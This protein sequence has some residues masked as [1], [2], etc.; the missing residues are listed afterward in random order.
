MTEPLQ[1]DGAIVAGDTLVAA[2]GKARRRFEAAGLEQPVLDARLLLEEAAGVARLDIVTDPHRPLTAAQ[3]Q[4]YERVAA[5]RAAR[6]PVSHILGRKGF[7]TL[8]LTVTP[9]VLSPRPETELLVEAVLGHA[10]A[11][12]PFTLLDLGT[13]S[14]AILLAVLAARPL[15]MGVGVDISAA[16]LAVA[17]ANAAALGLSSRAHWQRAD[18]AAGLAGAFDVVVANPPYIPTGDLET[19]SPEVRRF[20]PI[21]AL[22]GGADGLDAYR[23]LAGV[24]P[25]VVAPD[26]ALVLEV[27]A[28]QAQAVTALFEAAGFRTERVIKDL[29]GHA[30]T[31]VLRKRDG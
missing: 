28:G 22:D 17:G 10:P 29:A 23:A 16:A 19:L 20:D 6:E 18:W 27:G 14:G 21:L 15:A 2:W 31:L 3:A 12:A 30:R 7:W 25:G 26:G 11:D 5:R 24:T 9:D 1:H 8:T 4:A 13:G